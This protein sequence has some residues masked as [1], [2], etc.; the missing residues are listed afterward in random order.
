METSQTAVVAAIQL[1]GPKTTGESDVQ[2][3][4]RVLANIPLASLMLLPSAP[5]LKR[6]AKM[7][8]ATPITGVIVHFDR[9]PNNAKRGEIAF[10]STFRDKEVV[11][12][13]LKPITDFIDNTPNWNAVVNKAR[14][15]KA[16]LG[17]LGVE[18][19]T[20]E[21]LWERGGK[22]TIRKVSG[23]DGGGGLVGHKVTLYKVREDE[24]GNATSSHSGF[25]TAV[26]IEDLGVYQPA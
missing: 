21:P 17:E 10:V 1:A 7:V 15:Y 12:P 18:F 11:E 23:K 14:K 20:T 6:A 13:D 26:H 5:E 16:E 22:E 24:S 9:A 25:R 2:Y 3:R 19:F 8:A 4:N